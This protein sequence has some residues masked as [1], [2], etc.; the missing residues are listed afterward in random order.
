MQVSTNYQRFSLYDPTCDVAENLNE[1]TDD[2]IGTRDVG[3]APNALVVI[4]ALDLVFVPVTL[5]VFSGAP[6]VPV[7][8]EEADLVRAGRLELPGGSIAVAESLDAGHQVGV[9]LPEGPGTY[10][11]RVVGTGRRRASELFQS[12]DYGAQMPEPERDAIRASFEGI[13]SYRISLWQVST[14][15]HWDDDGEE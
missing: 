13:E 1:A 9:E 8:G 6:S 4:V 3:W 5:E 10:E 14:E 15:P 12:S 7:V 11:A 2:V